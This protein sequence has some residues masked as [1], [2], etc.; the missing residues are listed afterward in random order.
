MSAPK[1]GKAMARLEDLIRQIENDEI[2]V[3]DL[4]VKVKEAV[5]LIRVCKEKIEKAEMEVIQVVKDF[6]TEAVKREK[7]L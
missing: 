4:S 1:Y 2:D 6:K 3:D 5:E 7:I